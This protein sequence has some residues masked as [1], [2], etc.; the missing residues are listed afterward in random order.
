MFLLAQGPKGDVGDPCNPTKLP[1]VVGALKYYI[2]DFLL[3]A[4]L[5]Y[6]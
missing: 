4:R 2:F 5:F 1:T 3:N 6:S